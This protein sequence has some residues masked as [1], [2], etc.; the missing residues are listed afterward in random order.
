V[1][2]AIDVLVLASVAAFPLV[3]V[4]LVAIVMRRSAHRRDRPDARAELVGEAPPPIPNAVARAT[5]GRTFPPGTPLDRAL[6]WLGATNQATQAE[7]AAG[8]DPSSVLRELEARLGSISAALL[9]ES[10]L[11]RLERRP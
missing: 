10:E 4:E 9:R 6:G 2:E 5:A 8:H 3:V 11:A 1:L 7:L